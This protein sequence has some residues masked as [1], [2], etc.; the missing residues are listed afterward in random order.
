QL[1]RACATR[2]LRNRFRPRLDRLESRLAPANVN[3]LSNHYDGLLSG[4]NV[5]ETALT[6]GNVNATNFGRLFSYAVDGY[7]YAQPLYRA[8][9]ASPGRR[10]HTV[11]FAATEHDSVYAFDADTSTPATGGGLLWSRTFITPA[12]G[13]TTVPAPADVISS[14]IVP[15]IGITGAPVIDPA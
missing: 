12:A 9:L 15:E 3:V 10:T 11:V 6:P 8:N 1:R 2:S 7:V 14:D 5:Q 13:I 4:A